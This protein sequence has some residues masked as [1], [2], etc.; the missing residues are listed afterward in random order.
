MNK[1]HNDEHLNKMEMKR[2]D[3]EMKVIWPTEN[4]DTVCN[5]RLTQSTAS[6]TFNKKDSPDKHKIRKI[7]T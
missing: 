2:K 6:E 1:I 3:I 5:E 7:S 4:M